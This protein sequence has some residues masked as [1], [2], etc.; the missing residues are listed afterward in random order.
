ML[1][2]LYD[3]L[4]QARF[5]LPPGAD[6]KQAPIQFRRHA[7]PDGTVRLFPLRT[8]LDWRKKQ[9]DG[10]AAPEGDN[11]FDRY[12]RLTDEAC[13]LLCL[14]PTFNAVLHK[15]PRLKNIPVGFAP[16]Q[17]S[18]MGGYYKGKRPRVAVA[19]RLADAP[20]GRDA[21][22]WIVAH[23]LR[24][25]AQD[26]SNPV[27]PESIAFEDLVLHTRI[28]EADSCAFQT[29]VSWELQALGHDAPWRNLIASP[30]YG[31]IAKAFHDCAA[32]DAGSVESGAALNA[33]FAAW[34]DDTQLRRIYDRHDCLQMLAHLK[35]VR[36]HMRVEWVDPGKAPPPLAD[37]AWRRMLGARRDMASLN[38]KGRPVQRPDY[39]NAAMTGKILT[40]A[41]RDAADP[42][43]TRCVQ[44]AHDRIRNDFY[45]SIMN[46]IFSA[47]QG[48]DP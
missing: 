21:A 6:R 3:F 7:A 4:K 36:R 16:M 1:D 43:T 9:P 39:L 2:K 18:Y 31:P 27:L 35:D 17:G 22:P 32:K 30:K 26:L 48:M 15:H 37:K 45:A 47:Y 40:P 10:A 46:R 20:A 8:V 23:E 24:H 12:L 19:D 28:N 25:G 33:A 5:L 44:A 38:A 11:D 13:Q 41:F 29:V 34:F 14:S 42:R